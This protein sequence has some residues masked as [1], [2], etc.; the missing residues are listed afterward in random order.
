MVKQGTANHDGYSSKVLALNRKSI[1]QTGIGSNRL[2][3]CLSKELF[4]V[5]ILDRKGQEKILERMNMVISITSKTQYQKKT[6]I[7]EFP[8]DN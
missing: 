6:K 4:L 3:M 7:T 8:K 2:S 5:Y 1:L